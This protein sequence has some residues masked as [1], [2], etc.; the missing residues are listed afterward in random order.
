MADI[1]TVGDLRKLLSGIPDDIELY[2]A[3]TP[4]INGYANQILD[5]VG[6]IVDNENDKIMI[7]MGLKE[8]SAFGEEEAPINWPRRPI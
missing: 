6:T 2:V 8:E 4:D 7:F 3:P 5:M 1:K